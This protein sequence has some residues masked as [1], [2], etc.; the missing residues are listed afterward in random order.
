MYAAP[1]RLT[2]R[3]Q[4]YLLYR[5]GFTDSIEHLSIRAAL[6]FHL[7]ESRTKKMEGEEID[8]PDKE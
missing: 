8:S 5:Y 2:A 7:G 6:H 4:T 3:E 1:G